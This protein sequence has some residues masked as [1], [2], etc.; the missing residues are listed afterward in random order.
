LLLFAVLHLARGI[1]HVHGQVA[2]HLLVR[3]ERTP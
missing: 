2:K 1:G 3:G